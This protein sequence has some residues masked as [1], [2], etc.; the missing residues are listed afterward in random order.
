VTDKLNKALWQC[1]SSE[2]AI[3]RSHECCLTYR[4]IKE[5]ASGTIVEKSPR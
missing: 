1:E 3:P 5:R 4:S 2:S